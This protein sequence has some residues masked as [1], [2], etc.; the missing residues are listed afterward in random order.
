VQ[1]P[2][3]LEQFFDADLLR[4]VH[5][6]HHFAVAGQAGADFFVGRVGCE[7]AGVADHGADPA[8]LPE[9]ALG[10]PETAQ[11]ED[12]LLRPAGRAGSGL[13]LT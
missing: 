10:A 12:D 2:E 7:A 6:Q 5:H 8:L 13:P 4:V 3:H 11:A 9:A 1:L